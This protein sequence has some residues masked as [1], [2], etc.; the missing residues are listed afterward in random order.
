[1]TEIS[2]LLWRVFAAAVTG[3]IVAKDEAAVWLLPQLP[4]EHA[5]TLQAACGISGLIKQNWAASMPSVE[6]FVFYAKTD[7]RSA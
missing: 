4:A 1:V 7:C 2:S 3:N 6:R 5:D